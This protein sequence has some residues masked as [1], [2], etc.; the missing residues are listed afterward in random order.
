M[1]QTVHCNCKVHAEYHDTG[2]FVFSGL[3]LHCLK[4]FLFNNL[5]IIETDCW[6]LHIIGIFAF[7]NYL[8]YS[9]HLHIYLLFP[10]PIIPRL[11][12]KEKWIIWKMLQ[13][14]LNT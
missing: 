14:K 8:P 2:D 4:I 7:L 5:M 12:P 3:L 9:K 10:M 1:L 13:M 6:W 11:I